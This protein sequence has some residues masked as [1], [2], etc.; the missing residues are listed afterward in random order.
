MLKKA[1]ASPGRAVAMKR[2]LMVLGLTVSLGVTAGA[3]YMNRAGAAPAVT[4]SAVTRGDIVEI[5]GA[6]GTLQAVTTVQVGSQVSGNIIWLGADFNTIVRKG[7]VIAKLD[8]S[9][10]NAQAAQA[11]AN[12][13]KTQADVEHERV[14]VTDAEQKYARSRNLAARS[15][16]PQSDLDAA[17]VAVDEAQAQ[18][19]S[20]QAQV[21]QAQAALNQSQVNLDHTIITAPIDGIVI[22]RSV[23]VGQTVAASL[24]S[25]NVF[26]IAADLKE[27]QVNASIDEADIGQIRSGQHVTFTVDAYLG[28]QFTGTVLQVRLQPTVVSNVTTYSAIIDAP[29]PDL[30]LKPGMTA[31]LKV[32]VARRNQVVRV[33]NAAL[34][35]RP[36]TA[37]LAAFH[38]NPPA[39][40]AGAAS[41]VKVWT[42][43]NGTLTPLTVRVGISDGTNTE[44]VTG[45]VQPGADLVTAAAVSSTSTAAATRPATSNPLMGLQPAAGGRGAGPRP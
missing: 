23:D 17:K 37:I 38:Q 16:L 42:Y 22:Q 12:L 29:N 39:T 2:L 33:P 28:E 40:D 6:A 26:V 25:P 14:A 4:T 1:T 3:Y 24:S 15:L 45:D 35:F 31:N 8:A 34:R 21:A 19:R 27:M 7:Q 18:L 43:A 30:K 10:L 44:L 32:E 9:M 41:R 11:R 13:V 20:S 36:T 5:V